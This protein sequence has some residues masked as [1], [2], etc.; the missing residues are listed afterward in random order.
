MSVLG[1]IGQAFFYPDD[2]YHFKSEIVAEAV[3][4]QLGKSIDDITPDDLKA[5]TEIRIWGE[6]TIKNNEEI[7]WESNPGNYVSSFMINGEKYTARGTLDTLEDF[8]GMKNLYT[9]QLV[10]QDIKDLSPLSELE[11]VHLYLND[12]RIQDITPLK[13]VTSLYTLEIG[14]NPVSDF[15][16][17]ENLTGIGELDI[18]DTLCSDPSF[19]KNNTGLEMLK[20]RSLNI[21]RLDF[22]LPLY[23]LRSLD[24]EHNQITE[25]YTIQGLNKL[26]F[27]NI[28][29]NPITDLS[30]INEMN[31]IK[32]VVIR[33][34]MA[35]QSIIRDG[36]K[37]VNH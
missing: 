16:A 5:I 34:T 3:S 18:S 20:A 2:V 25:I 19:I 24:L 4:S 12:N 10:K 31:G 9:L 21:E 33:D 8:R 22:L 6:R 23:K 17:I 37:I 32:S 7:T 11:I 36:I 27:L 14:G 15:S 26:E 30:G 35:D 1:V 28:A 13:N 29:D